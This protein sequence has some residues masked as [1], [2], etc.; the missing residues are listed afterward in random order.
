MLP[1]ADGTRALFGPP[2]EARCLVSCDATILFCA[3][4]PTSQDDLR[5][6]EAD[7]NKNLDFLAGGGQPPRDGLEHF[8]QLWCPNGTYSAHGQV[9][10]VPLSQVGFAV[11]DGVLVAIFHFPQ[12]WCPTGAHAAHGQVLLVPPSQ[13]RAWLPS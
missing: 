2:A 13:V 8:P 3:T 11:M 12:L 7:E 5:Y 9:F 6:L 1:G 10:L 4:L